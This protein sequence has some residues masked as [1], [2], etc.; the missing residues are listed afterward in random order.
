MRLSSTALFRT[1]R[2]EVVLL[3]NLERTD[4]HGE[5]EVFVERYRLE[6]ASY[7]VSGRDREDAPEGT[8]GEERRRFWLPADTPVSVSPGDR[9]VFCDA[10]YTV[11]QVQHWR[12]YTLADAELADQSPRWDDGEDDPIPQHAYMGAVQ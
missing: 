6:A 8:F 12:A 1:R 2:D 10:E 3:R 7:I 4:R 5:Q 11:D 9:L